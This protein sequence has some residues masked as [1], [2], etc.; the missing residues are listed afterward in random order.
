[1]A[2]HS[3]RR[4]SGIL[5]ALLLA[6]ANA[7]GVVHDLEAHGDAPIVAHAGTRFEAAHERPIADVHVEST[8]A[9]HTEVC[10]VCSLRRAISLDGTGW[11]PQAASPPTAIVGLAAADP[12]PIAPAYGSV[13][14]RSPPLA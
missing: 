14:G 1:M 6:L 5:A 2:R 7:G 11:T 4:A 3:H 12:A 9:R 13:R 10:V 8:V